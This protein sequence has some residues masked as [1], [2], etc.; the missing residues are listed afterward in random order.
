MARSRL[1]SIFGGFFVCIAWAPNDGRARASKIGNNANI[2]V[3]EDD[4]RTPL[5]KDSLKISSTA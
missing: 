4:I 3:R 5:L 2:A 1:N